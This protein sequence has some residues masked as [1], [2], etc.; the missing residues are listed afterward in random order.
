MMSGPELEDCLRGLGIRILTM[1]GYPESHL[2]ARFGRRLDYRSFLPKPFTSTTLVEAVKHSLANWPRVLPVASAV[3]SQIS[4]TEAANGSVNAA[5]QSSPK[6][7]VA[8]AW[9]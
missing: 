8:P 1:S 2:F 7:K 5:A 9:L 4:S 3:R 6:P